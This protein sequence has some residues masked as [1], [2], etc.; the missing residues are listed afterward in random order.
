MTYHL[1]AGSIAIMTAW[2]ATMATGSL[3]RALWL[4]CVWSGLYVICVYAGG[5]PGWYLK[6]PDGRLSWW[7]V[8]L[9]GPYL[10]LTHAILRIKRW[11]T[12]ESPYDEVAPNLLVGSRLLAA[13]AAR[14]ADAPLAAVL[15]LTC[16]LA[17]VRFLRSGPAAYKCLQVLDTRPLTPA[18]LAEACD[19]IDAHIDRGPVYVH[20]AA[21][22]GRS[23]TVAA[24]WMVRAGLARDAADAN[25]QMKRAR[26]GI[27]INRG[28][29]RLL[30]QFLRED[31]G[32]APDVSPVTSS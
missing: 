26:P 16:E 29:W 6:R 20:C 28:Q 23:A 21:G 22:H 27:Y 4:W 25:D 3:S 31:D 17:E 2:L 15:D 5:R 24:A 11:V 19:F 8:P 7:A 10:A 13:D 12:R 18:Q 30:E 1:T 9:F 32:D 14:F